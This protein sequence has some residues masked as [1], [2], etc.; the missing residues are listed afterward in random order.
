MIDPASFGRTTEFRDRFVEH[1]WRATGVGELLEWPAPL[2]FMTDL[3]LDS[4]QPMFL[5]WGPDHTILFNEAFTSILGPKYLEALGAQFPKLWANAWAEMGRFFEDAYKGNA[6]LAEDQLVSTWAS[7]FKEFRYYSF[8]YTPIRDGGKILGVICVCTDTTERVA[9]REQMRS[10]R[11]ALSLAFEHAPGFIAMTEGPDHRFT[12]ANAAYRRLIGE[13]DV[14]GKRVAD[15]LPEVVEQGFTALLDEVYE[16]GEP[17]TAFAMP[18][19]LA[20]GGEEGASRFIDF[21]YAP[22]LSAEGRIVG[23]FCEGQ[24]V[25]DRV[26]YTNQIRK[27]QSELIHAS[28]RSAMNVLA[29]TLAH[30]LNQ[31]LAAIT[32]YADAARR[33]LEDSSVDKVNDC[34][35]SIA[36]SALRAGRI[37]RG[38]RN[39]IE[40]RSMRV[41][42]VAV[43]DIIREAL[44]LLGAVF[45]NFQVDL[46][47][48]LYVSGDRVQIQQVIVNVVRNAWDAAGSSANPA[49]AISAHQRDGTIRTTVTDNGSG[50]AMEPV[51]SIFAAFS[52]SKADG[53][54]MGLAISRT[55]IEAHGGRIWAENRACGGASV[56]FEL[57]MLE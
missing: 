22:R 11:D 7:G 2:K 33:L 35:E 20:N 31:P 30:E 24:E 32:N 9:V 43:D 5:T 42:V 57:P 48:N 17:I 8:S 10:E 47:S 15:A 6:A 49:V 40:K 52:T 38:A 18:I 50:I 25:T 3:L 12:F 16:T 39:M 1:D 21:V 29:S 19:R 54:G 51:D 14:V 41:E 27:L 45:S 55:I 26:E 46:E 37:I 36:E 23:L 44:D 56:S 53:L 4:K 13:R 28:R 34:L